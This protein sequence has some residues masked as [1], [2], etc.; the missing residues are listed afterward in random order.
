MT[1]TK[2]VRE[3]IA[4]A[5]EESM[6]APFELPIEGELH[7]RYLET[8]AAALS[9]LTLADHIAA[10]EAAGAHVVVPAKATRNQELRG[11]DQIE[12]QYLINKGWETSK[13]VIENLDLAAIYRDMLAARPRHE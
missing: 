3:R 4:R 13:D 2:D 5:I 7:R 6:F 11:G 10:V 8:A 1:D 12:E 9:T